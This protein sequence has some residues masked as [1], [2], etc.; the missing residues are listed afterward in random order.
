MIKLPKPMPLPSAEEMAKCTT[1]VEIE[2]GDTN[3]R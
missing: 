1:I 2:E 3:E